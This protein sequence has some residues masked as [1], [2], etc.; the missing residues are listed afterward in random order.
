MEPEASLLAPAGPESTACTAF[1]RLTQ[2]KR[3]LQ[4]EIDEVKAQLEALEP[5]ILAY[6][7]STGY[8]MV[9]VEGFTLSPHRDPWIGPAEGYTKEDV[10]HALKASDMEQ[11]VTESYN[12]RS[13]TKYVRDL[14]KEH[15]ED[16]QQD[17][18][19]S[20]LDLHVL[21]RPLARVIMIK[22][23]YSIQAKPWRK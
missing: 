9:R 1:A 12:S 3:D 11:Y 10:T 22:P 7:S 19:E 2:R 16:L 17:G 21:P 15:Q 13:L 20:I 5:E 4:A 8:D 23:T 18:I 14:E 6:L